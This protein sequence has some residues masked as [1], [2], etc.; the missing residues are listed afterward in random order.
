M[1]KHAVLGQEPKLKIEGVWLFRG[2][3]IPQEAI[4]HPQFEYYKKR[5]LDM[6]KKEDVEMLRDFWGSKEEDTIN[7]DFV[8]LMAKHL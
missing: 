7:G 6:S 2:T 8:Q 4:D 3:T 5:Q 1:A